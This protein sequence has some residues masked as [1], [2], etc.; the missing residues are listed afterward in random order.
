M[1]VNFEGHQSHV[2]E[3]LML[4]S[5][6]YA[7]SAHDCTVHIWNLREGTCL[8]VLTDHA[9]HKVSGLTRY[10]NKLISADETNGTIL[11]HHFPFGTSFPQTR[12]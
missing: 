10:Q 2:N 4:D 3:F 11:F 9:D 5:N 7:S 6:T 1:I 8:Q 12:Q